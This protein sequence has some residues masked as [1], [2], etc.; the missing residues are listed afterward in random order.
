[1]SEY[2]VLIWAELSSAANVGIKDTVDLIDDLGFDADYAKATYESIQ[3]GT[4]NAEME[5]DLR[6][7][8]FNA[9]G[10]NF[11]WGMPEN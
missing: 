7:Y 4:E 10:L 5:S 2:K 9:I 1:M 6:E 8:A 11:G 3:A